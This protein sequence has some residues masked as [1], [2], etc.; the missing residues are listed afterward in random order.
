M[1]YPEEF[2]QK[3]L[4]TLGNSEELKKRLDE[5][6]EIVGRILDDSSYNTI[7]AKEIVDACESMN[8]QGLYN[9]AKQVVAI[10]ELYEEWGELHNEQY[11]GIRK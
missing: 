9:K 2:K 8:L 10:E 3:V 6:Q 11:K 4:S 7:S 5:G 1:Q